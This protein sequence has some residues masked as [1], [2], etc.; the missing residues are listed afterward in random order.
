MRVIAWMVVL[1][2]GV[3][4]PAHAEPSIS[5]DE[6]RQYEQ[7][8]GQLARE[9]RHQ[10]AAQ[11]LEKTVGRRRLNERRAQE[12][13]TATKLQWMA[14]ARAAER[15]GEGK[16]A[17]A[18][19]KRAREL[20]PGDPQPT[21]AIAAMQERLHPSV[22]TVRQA[23]ELNLIPYKPFTEEYT[24]N[25]GDVIEV[26]VWQQPDLTRDVVVRPDG[27]L[28][29]P[30]VGDVEAAG[31]ALTQLDQVI[32]QRLKAYVKIPDVSVAIR[33]FGGTKTIVLGEIGTPGIYIP[34]ED[35][36][37]LDVIA[38][39]GG[40]KDHAVRD[41]VMLIRGDR[42]QPQVAKLNLSKAL[43]LGIMEENV[44]LQPNDIVFV[45][46]QRINTVLDFMDDFYPA[47]DEL[48]VGQSLATGFGADPRIRKSDRPRN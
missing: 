22:P 32:T 10:E 13:R 19:W 15:K 33:R 38:M 1:A 2:L 29:L 16:R 17:L 48:L 43:T 3:G 46:K 21:Q 47:I 6:V 27:R 42:R 39:A 28:S 8:A 26:F 41:N 35:G 37:V 20:D 45:P 36:R 31:M 7:I 23:A 12:R 9:G 40:F 24:I 34:T 11:L 30:L 18:L 4:A 25:R 5:E 14:Q 44:R